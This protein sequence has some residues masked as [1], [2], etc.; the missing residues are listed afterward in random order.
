MNSL[1]FLDSDTKSNKK[2]ENTTYSPE[3]FQII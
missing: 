3:K 2:S 1:R